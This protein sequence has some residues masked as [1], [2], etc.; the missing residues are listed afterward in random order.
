MRRKKLVKRKGQMVKTN[1]ALVASICQHQFSFL[2]TSVRADKPGEKTV[3]CGCDVCGF[4]KE[5]VQ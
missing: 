1:E 2:G 3:L 4:V 5:R